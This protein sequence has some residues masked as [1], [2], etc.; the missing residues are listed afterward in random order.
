MSEKVTCAVINDDFLSADYDN[1]KEI[2]KTIFFESQFRAMD[3]TFFS[4]K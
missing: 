2:T 1:Q 3:H 4:I